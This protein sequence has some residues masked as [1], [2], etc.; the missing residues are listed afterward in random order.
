[1]TI[2]SYGTLGE[3]AFLEI[4]GD[5]TR[6]S[7]DNDG[8]PPGLTITTNR[9][10]GMAQRQWRFGP[11]GDLTFPNGAL[12]I[13]GNTISNYVA[14]DMGASGSQLEVSQTK[15][16]I[17]NGV[18]N[19]LSGSTSLIGQSLFEVS[20]NGILSSF[21]VINTLD[22]TSLTSEYLTELDNLSFKIGQ[23]I[24]NDLGDG[25]EP[26]VAFSGWTFSTDAP[27]YTKTLTLP[28]N[29][30]ILTNE[31]A[32][33]IA[34]HST[35]TYTF[36]QAYWEAVDGDITRVVTPTGNAQYFAC[37]V[38]RNQDSTYTAAVTNAGISFVPGNWFKVPGD[39]LGGAT[40][41]NDI[42]ITVATVNGSGTILTTT[43]TGTAVGKQ[44]TF[45]TDGT[46]TLPGAVVKSTVAKTGVADLYANDMSFQVTAVDGGGVVTEVTITNT[47]NI[48]WQS[49]GAGTGV[50]VGDLSFTVQV[51]GSGNAT[52]SG[53]TSSGGH[54]IDETFTVGGDSFGAEILPTAID[55][56]KTVNKLTDGIYSLADGVEGQ[57]MYLVRQN[58]STAA[59]IS[60]G[61]AN[62]RWDGTVYSDQLVVP[63]QIPFTDMVTII[64]TDG[65]WQS[66]TFGIPT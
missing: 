51:D 22:D 10:G 34:T 7:I 66:S 39:E 26:L 35:T 12:K 16:V 37:T 6:I 4:G 59:N 52:V 58:G 14:D 5:D 1:M 21:Q 9:T 63:F 40:P 30:S 55:L 31:T 57:V 43:V 33:N 60:V 2:D 62:A 28:V 32:L 3:N 46:T 47:P 19:T 54:T 45:D 20:T 48:A 29:S 8:A 25:S 49:N 64:F 24:T 65:A 61:V 56:T 38:T 41:A 44:W 13:A 17:T 50:T 53:I 15:T 11:D 36:N 18:T 23:R 42:Q 27:G